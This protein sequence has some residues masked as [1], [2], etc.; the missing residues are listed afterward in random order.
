M[1]RTKILKYLPT[2]FY[3]KK[4]V[5]LSERRDL[6]KIMINCSMLLMLVLNATII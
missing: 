4:R 2:T 3:G 1:A 5:R 6:W